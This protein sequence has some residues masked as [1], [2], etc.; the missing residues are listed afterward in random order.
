M[1]VGSSNPSNQGVLGLGVRPFIRIRAIC[2]RDHDLELAEE[3]E[4]KVG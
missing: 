4:G 2:F 3:S 1:E